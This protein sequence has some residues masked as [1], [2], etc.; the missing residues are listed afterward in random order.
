MWLTQ[1]APNP[2]PGAVLLPRI[3]RTPSGKCRARDDPGGDEL[4]SKL[5]K[6]TGLSRVR[7]QAPESGAPAPPEAS[8]EQGGPAVPSQ[9]SDWAGHDQ[10]WDEWKGEAE[11]DLDDAE[12]IAALRS[13]VIKKRRARKGRRSVT[14]DE[15]LRPI[16]DFQ[17]IRDRLAFDEQD[18]EE[19]VF[20][21]AATNQFESREAVKYAGLIFGVSIV[22]GFAVSR[23]LA[24]PLWTYAAGVN[25]AAFAMSDQ[26][27]FEAVEE[28]HAEE[29]R[30][31]MEAT[32]GQA[33]PL[34]DAGVLEH[35]RAEA[36][37]I[38]GEYKAYN[39]AAL[40]NLVSDSVTGS[41]IFAAL[42][43]N[44]SQRT[45]LF[46]TIGRIL[47][48]LSDTAKAFLI[49]LVTDTLLGY[50]SEEGW[51]AAAQ[52]FTQHYGFHPSED[53]IQIFVSI[54]P[55]CLDSYFKYWIFVGLN[56]QDPAAAVT[57]RNMDRH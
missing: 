3:S 54:V 38:Q 33:P 19:R 45:I 4:R 13:A 7:R 36:K 11:P 9:W 29:L 6:W 41:L 21:E 53:S 18:S 52:L 44:N 48:G 14:R 2:W 15:W 20:I 16:V 55:V 22:A 40:T 24:E 10:D 27:K 8:V 47:S 23:L 49:I 56:K 43:Q 42:L 34:S 28:I 50:H 57:L 32:V 5:S 37:R 31:Q 26:Q 12:D 1:R 35:L 30:L 39:R 25:P 17:G 51:T 46:R